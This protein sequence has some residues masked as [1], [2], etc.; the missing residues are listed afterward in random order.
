M[1]SSRFWR[2]MGEADREFGIDFYGCYGN[3]SG[4][5]IV[6]V[7]DFSDSDQRH[8]VALYRAAVFDAANRVAAADGAA[9]D[10]KG[11]KIG[12]DNNWMPIGG[13][14]TTRVYTRFRTPFTRDGT[15]RLVIEVGGPFVKR[16]QEFP[17]TQIQTIRASQEEQRHFFGFP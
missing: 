1:S 2:R 13:G 4:G 15:I 3:E 9:S 6:C 10:Y 16:R 8:R 5:T 17:A 11:Y 14:G 12:D 7:T